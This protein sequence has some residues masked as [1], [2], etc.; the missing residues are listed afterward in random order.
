MTFIRK[1]YNKRDNFKTQFKT[2]ISF[3]HFK[4]Y[5]KYHLYIY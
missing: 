1:D 4:N 2:L 3:K 5:S